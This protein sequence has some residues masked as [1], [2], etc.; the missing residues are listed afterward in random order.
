MRNQANERY[1]TFQ[2]PQSISKENKKH[3]KISQR[4]D[5]SNDYEMTA[6]NHQ[7]E[8]HEKTIF[9]LNYLPHRLRLTKEKKLETLKRHMKELTK[10]IE[11]LRQKLAYYK[12]TRKVLMKFYESIDE[13][14]RVIENA[15]CETVKNVAISE[16]R[17]LDYWGVHHDDRNS[18]DN[19]F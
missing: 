8:N 7:I 6:L 14:H 3:S 5:F 10:K 19:V 13:L 18:V 11:Y 17:L 12:N 4:S 2:L 9:I 16:Q 15:L 1:V